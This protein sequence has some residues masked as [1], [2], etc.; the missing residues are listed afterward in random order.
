MFIM[1]TYDVYIYIHTKQL[2]QHYRSILQ[3]IEDAL[4]LVASN[5]HPT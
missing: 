3:N 4:Y 1:Y 5:V 2:C